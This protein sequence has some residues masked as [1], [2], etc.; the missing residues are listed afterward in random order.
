MENVVGNDDTFVMAQEAIMETAIDATPPAEMMANGEQDEHFF[1]GV[2]KL[3]EIWFDP[4]QD[5]D[6]RKVPR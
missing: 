2:E 3:L 6:L 4:V 1:E 5:A